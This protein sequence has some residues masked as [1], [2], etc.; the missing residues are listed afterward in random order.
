MRTRTD[1]AAAARRLW[2]DSRPL[3]ATWLRAI[4]MLRR[5]SHGWVL[6]RGHGRL[7]GVRT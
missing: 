6:E 3:Q 5:T 4:R 7:D 2:P 1:L